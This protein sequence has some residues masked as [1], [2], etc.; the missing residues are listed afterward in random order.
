MGAGSQRLTGKEAYLY[1]K[2]VLSG[3]AKKPK[4]GCA[5]ASVVT[6]DIKK[7]FF[8]ASLIDNLIFLRDAK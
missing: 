7:V 2:T 4:P 1:K 5:G 8:I 6:G 3:T